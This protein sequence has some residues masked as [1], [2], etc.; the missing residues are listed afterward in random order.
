VTAAR[1]DVDHLARD[2]RDAHLADLVALAEGGSGDLALVALVGGEPARLARDGRAGRGD[3]AGH[4]RIAV[5]DRPELIDALEQ[6]GEAVRVEDDVDDVR[7][8]RLVDGA[9]LVREDRPVVS[10]APAQPHEAGAVGAQPRAQP[11]EDAALDV[12]AALQ[13]VLARLQCGDRPLEM[14]DPVA[15]VLRRGPQR[16]L[17]GLERRRA[18]GQVA[19][20]GR[21]ADPR[22]DRGEDQHDAR[23]AGLHDRSGRAGHE[24]RNG[25]AATVARCN[26]DGMQALVQRSFRT[27]SGSDPRRG[28]LP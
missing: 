18:A 11:G 16:A 10:E 2:E 13:A 4:L 5:P 23:R 24:R 26:H 27:P 28:R 6:L 22:P 8:R 7:R 25:S 1:A 19:A 3:L 15:V 17:L 12:E 9:Q 20:G 14:G 21:R